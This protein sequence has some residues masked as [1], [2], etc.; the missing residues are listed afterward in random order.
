MEDPTTLKTKTR[1]RK[2]NESIWRKKANS[3]LQIT[4]RCVGAF[5]DEQ[6]RRN[7][8]LV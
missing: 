5:Q 4:G 8:K 3:A 2:K 6:E 1:S 7:A